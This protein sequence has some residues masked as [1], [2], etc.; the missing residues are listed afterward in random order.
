MGTEHRIAEAKCSKK[1]QF[2]SHFKKK[3]KVAFKRFPYLVVRILSN[4]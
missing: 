1:V 3:I 4:N 2:N